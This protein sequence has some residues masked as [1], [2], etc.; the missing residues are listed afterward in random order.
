M[1]SVNFPLF[2]ILQ[3]NLSV[4]NKLPNPAVGKYHDET[5]E[6]F[7]PAARTLDI[8]IEAVNSLVM[9]KASPIEMVPRSHKL[10]KSVE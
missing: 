6:F 4:S 3:S 1:F 9:K 2:Y 8:C 10:Q 5:R 7:A